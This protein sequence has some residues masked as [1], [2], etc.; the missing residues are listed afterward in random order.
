[1]ESELEKSK[2]ELEV[3]QPDN[4]FSLIWK[5]PI[6]LCFLLFISNFHS[7]FI[8]E[9]SHWVMDTGSFIHLDFGFS[10]KPFIQYKLGEST[11][12]FVFPML[13]DFLI[14]FVLLAFFNNNVF[15]QL[16][17]LYLLAFQFRQVGGTDYVGLFPVWLPFAVFLFFYS[18]IMLYKLSRFVRCNDER[19]GYFGRY[20]VAEW[21]LFGI[22]RW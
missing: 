16:Y 3:G 20:G 8:H 7:N 4:K 21:L 6:M 18:V 13:V 11:L 2:A 9:G 19:C 22:K 1:L 14:L 10:P 15:S 17:C 5:L 12:F